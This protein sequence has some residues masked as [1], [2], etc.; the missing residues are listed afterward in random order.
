MKIKGTAA[1]PEITLSSTPSLPNDEVLAQVL[2]GRSAAQLSPVEAAQ[3]ASSLAALATGGGFDVIG[4]L[5]EFVKLD[6]LAFGGGDAQNGLTVSGGKYVS[7]NVYLELT[8]GGRDGG[9]AQV[10]W[11]VRRNLSVVSRVSGAG[12]TRLSVRWKQDYGRK[13]KPAGTGPA[14]K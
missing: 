4:G 3:L 2:F 14:V 12:D 5:R 1:K 13:A 9:S 10:E 6:R 7:D 11:R 8:G